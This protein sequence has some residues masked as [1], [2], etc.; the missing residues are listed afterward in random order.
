M[1]IEESECDEWANLIQE[2]EAAKTWAMPLQDFSIPELML[3]RVEDAMIQS[4][5]STI[6]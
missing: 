3:P 5:H 2:L 1:S 4:W 6:H